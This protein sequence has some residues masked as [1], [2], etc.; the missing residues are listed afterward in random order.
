MSKGFKKQTRYHY[1][2]PVYNK[3]GEWLG[4]FE[5]YTLAI[6]PAQAM[7]NLSFQAKRKFGLIPSAYLMLTNDSLEAVE[8][9]KPIPEFHQMELFEME[10]FNV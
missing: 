6:S 8:I 5:G 3:F 7:N 9:S 2:G 10:N 1:K 4:G